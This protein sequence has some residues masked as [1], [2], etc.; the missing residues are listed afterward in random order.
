[1]SS[2]DA[3][4]VFYS[5][6][7]KDLA[8]QEELKTHLG[9]LRRQQIISGWD[10]RDL[11]PGE[12][13]DH[14]IKARLNSADIILLL[15]SP[16]FINSDYCYDIEV[17]RAIERHEA[18]EACVIPIILRP[19][20]WKH[21]DVPFNKLTALPMG[22]EPVTKWENQDEAFL[23]IAQGI[24]KAAEK[25]I[26]ERRE[27]LQNTNITG[28][29]SL[30]GYAKKY[31]ERHAQ[32]KLLRMPQAI[33]LETIY[34]KVRFLDERNPF[35]SLESLEQYHREG[36]RR[37]LQM[38]ECVELDGFTAVNENACLMVLG[39]PGAGK[40]TF[41]RRIGLEALKVG[42]DGAAEYAHACIPVF[43]EL[44]SFRDAQVDL[45]GAIEQELGRLGAPVPE[46]GVRTALAAGK[47]LIL[48][49]GLDEVPKA[50]LDAV[51]GAIQA[52]VTE[53]DQNRF[54]ASCRIA[55]YRSS[56]SFQ[57]F[58]DIELAEFDDGQMQQFIGNW[59]RSELDTA[60]QTADKCWALLD[61]EPHKAAKE[62][63]HTPLLLTFLCLV[64]DRTQGFPNKPAEL[65]RRAL[66]ILL[67]E[68]AAEKRIQQ[69][70]VYEGLNTELEKVMLAEIAYMGFVQDQL[71]FQQQDL[72]EQIRAFLSDTVDKPKYLDGKKVLDAIA[73][74]QGVLVE[75]AA[76]IYSF[77]H[78]TIQEYL[79]A[80]YISQDSSLVESL[81]TQHLTEKRWREVFLLVAGLLPRNADRL[82][83]L[84]EVEALKLIDTPRL[85]SLLEW[86]NEV[87]EG[88]NGV[89]RLTAK[90]VGA[91]ILVLTL[92]LDRD[93]ALTVSSNRD[94]YATLNNNIRV[95]SIHDIDSAINFARA[96]DHAFSLAQAL[97]LN[98]ASIRD[99]SLAHNLALVRERGENRCFV[100][101]SD[102]DRDLNR[103]LNRDRSRV[104]EFQKT[105]ILNLN[106]FQALTDHFQELQLE[107]SGDISVKTRQFYRDRIFHLWRDALRL[108]PDLI[109][110]TE[111]EL[112]T[113]ENYLYAL[114]LIIRCKES[115]VRVTESVWTGIEER[116]LKVA[117]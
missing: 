45:V 36:Q 105:D 55:A 75:R 44:K 78:L 89:L 71:F 84:M 7:R 8:L 46:S 87:T 35:L 26:R 112:T 25:L 38:R 96:L 5:Y 69:D 82:L 24:R 13:W 91:L 49:D 54:I 93:L 115:A 65:Y 99:R 80:Q 58:R 56:S 95:N 108:N 23:N 17:K 74:D 61:S 51:M 16:D 64:Y 114:E 113:L 68:W 30:Q 41:L 73:I 53:Y 48:L 67:E 86:T 21:K 3:V 6:S 109:A 110:F 103:A 70:A 40:S 85:Q 59:F 88:S 33:D 19:S 9:T 18:G 15:V 14:V 47:F 34:T 107:I 77:S 100:L 60:N 83:E 4:E 28:M 22:V 57:R 92:A 52:F 72:V 39:A 117:E 66:D 27:R 29:E 104:L 81:V 94:T 97:N 116:M 90:R 20:D 106:S 11:V 42:V 31:R 111:A 43:L 1:M 79:T 2:P 62:L 98:L 32:I 10:D 50:N 102:H 101:S 76:S 37:G 63:A 12:D